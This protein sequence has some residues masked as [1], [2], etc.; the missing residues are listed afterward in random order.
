MLRW[1]CSVFVWTIKGAGGQVIEPAALQVWVELPVELAKGFE[2][3][4]ASGFEHAGKL[5][6]TSNTELILHQ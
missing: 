5:A 3:D 1:R 2:V 4:E 6:V